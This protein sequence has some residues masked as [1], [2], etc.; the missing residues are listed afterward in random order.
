MAHILCAYKELHRESLKNKRLREVEWASDTHNSI[1]DN[2]RW[3][4]W[5][6]TAPKWT[7]EVINAAPTYSLTHQYV[8]L[9]GSSVSRGN[10]MTSDFRAVTHS[11][12][13]NTGT[14]FTLFMFMLL[15][16]SF[17]KHTQITPAA[18]S[19]QIYNPRWTSD[20]TEISLTVKDQIIYLVIIHD[21]TRAWLVRHQLTSAWCR[22]FDMN[23][24]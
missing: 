14:I 22:Y 11:H 16:V 4:T 20:H 8:C 1:C 3:G 12:L 23:D 13:M 15:A 5:Q 24:Q 6:T 10:H 9:Y 17:F 18:D 7:H 19:C 21:S 2:T